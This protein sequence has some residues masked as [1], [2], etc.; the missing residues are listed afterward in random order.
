MTG[1]D[2]LL[3]CKD[4]ALIQKEIEERKNIIMRASLEEMGSESA[5]N[6]ADELESLNKRKFKIVAMLESTQGRDMMALRVF[7]D[8][9]A[10]FLSY[11]YKETFVIIPRPS[12]YFQGIFTYTKDNVAQGQFKE[13]VDYSFSDLDWVIAHYLV[14]W[15]P[16]KSYCICY[17]IKDLKLSYPEQH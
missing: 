5:L 7:R 2:F 16:T 17:E 8:S 14:M 1:M 9:I 3:R 10:G 4:I 15:F 13:I 11:Y 6:I 12:G